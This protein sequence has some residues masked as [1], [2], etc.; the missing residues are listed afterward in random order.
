MLAAAVLQTGCATTPKWE[1]APFFQ[2]H[3]RSIL[4]VPASNVTTAVNAA[5]IWSTT[6]TMPLAERGYY[7]FPVFMTA[8]LLQDLGLT[9]EALIEQLAP[10]RFRELF[11][12]D[13]VC[14][15]TIQDWST[16]YLV[17]ASNVTVHLTYKLVDT[18]TG[19]VLWRGE[20]KAIR[21]SGGGGGGIAGL[22]AAAISALAT[23]AIDYRPIAR[24]ANVMM[25]RAERRG[26]PAGPYHPE[27]QTDYG[28]YK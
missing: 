19:L 4:V 1:Y 27:Y 28:K 18:R 8:D 24:E 10:S 9:N 26:L 25:L 16:K 17:L 21:Q 3:P 14:F 7:V 2:N 23:T 12:A 22:F 6:V 11:G 13:A 15:V 5:E 20:Q